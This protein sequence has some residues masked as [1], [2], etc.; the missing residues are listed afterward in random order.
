[1]SMYY[2]MKEL[3]MNDNSR[4]LNAYT[5]G[6]LMASSGVFSQIVDMLQ[7]NFYLYMQYLIYE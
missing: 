2:I 5:S 3:F 6:S 7:N 4:I 1:M